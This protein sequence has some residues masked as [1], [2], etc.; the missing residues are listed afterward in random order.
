MVLP[1]TRSVINPASPARSRIEL[2]L[3]LA[4]T[5]AKRKPA[6]RAASR[7]SCV[8]AYASHAF[9]IEAPCERFVLPVGKPVNR[10][11]VG[12]VVDEAVGQPDPAA[13]EEGMGAL[14]ARLA[15]KVLV[16]VGGGD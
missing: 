13:C 8:S 3:A 15:M 6:S 10:L 11:G 16:I 4:E 12:R 14:H 2:V 9:A 7:Y 5:T 1:S